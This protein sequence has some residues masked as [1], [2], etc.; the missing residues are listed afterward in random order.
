MQVSWRAVDPVLDKGS[1]GGVGCL[2]SGMCREGG[3]VCAVYG[4]VIKVQGQFISAWNR[5]LN[6]RSL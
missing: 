3:A 1:R 2:P 6:D 4:F 5:L